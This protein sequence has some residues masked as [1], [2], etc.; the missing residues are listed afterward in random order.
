M[1]RILWGRATSVNV[2]KVMWVLA[3]LRIAHERRDAGGAFGWPEE[4]EG[5]TPN[6]RIPVW[7]DGD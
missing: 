4:L 1:S 3:E 5:L 7:Q 2:Q 6:R